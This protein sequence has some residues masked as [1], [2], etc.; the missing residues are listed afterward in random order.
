M[1]T[2]TR[3]LALKLRSVMRCAFGTIRGDGPALCITGDAEALRVR[4]AYADVA[5]EYR[6]EGQYPAETL[7]LPFQ[8]LADC[9][10]KKD[11]PVELNASGKGRVTAQWQDGNVPIITTYQKPEFNAGEF[12]PMPEVLADNPTNL[13]TALREAFD[14]TDRESIRYTL[15]CVQLCGQSGLI[16]AT[17][18]RQLLVQSG[19]NLPWKEDLLIPRSGV[20]SCRDLALDRPV[21]IGRNEDWLSLCT[22][23]WT[24]HLRINKEGR[25]P[26][27]S[28]YIPS[29]TTARTSCHIAGPDAEF[30][31][32]T[33]PRLPCEDQSNYAIT[34]DLN[35]SIALRARGDNQPQPTEVV[36]AN[37][38][39]T[40]E[41]VK[42]KHQPPLSGPGTANGPIRNANKRPGIARCMPRRSPAVRMDAVGGRVGH[43]TMCQGHTH[44]LALGGSRK[45]TT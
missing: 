17:D 28:R 21:A 5:V 9:E 45:S 32:A 2:I 37:S 7:L 41:G 44:S 42:A 26:D 39:Y 24:I 3:R 11:Q 6:Q 1:L 43:Q 19:F 31:A 22:G 33:L 18:G 13:F 40:G 23:P 4:A 14:T 35:G 20:F 29:G 12:P 34:L 30:L 8:F 27:L 36:L 15:A 10:G 38:S 16:R 25:Y